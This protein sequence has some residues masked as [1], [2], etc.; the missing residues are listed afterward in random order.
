[1]YPHSFGLVDCALMARQN[2]AQ[3]RRRVL[4]QQ[5]ASAMRVA[6]GLAVAVAALAAAASAAGAED[7]EGSAGSGSFG[8]GSVCSGAEDCG[9][10]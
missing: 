10:G 7:S 5:T 8:S 1:M 9:H 6:A 3:E 4:M 2:V